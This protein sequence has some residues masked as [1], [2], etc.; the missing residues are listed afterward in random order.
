MYREVFFPGSTFKVVTGSIGVDTG[1]VTP[2]QPVYPVETGYDI[3]SPSATCR[4]SAAA[5][6][7]G[8]CSRSCG[9]RATAPS[10]R[11]ATRHRRA[12][13][14]SQGSERFGFNARPPIDLPAAA[15][16]RFPTEFPADQGNGPIA[17]ASIGQGDTSATP[18]Q[19]ALVAAAVANEGRIMAPH[20]LRKISDPDGR[21]IRDAKRPASGR[22]P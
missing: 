5:R 7:A 14:W 21:T 19:M 20:L 9:C 6:A 11:W 17:Q 4:T 12:R 18:L 22:R 13:A 2:D 16:S 15:A 3:D 8:R 10:P 1:K